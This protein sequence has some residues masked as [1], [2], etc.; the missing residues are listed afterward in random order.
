MLAL[1]QLSE[2]DER[3]IAKRLFGYVYSS[4]ISDTGFV[5]HHSDS[6]WE[7]VCR[8]LRYFDPQGEVHDGYQATKSISQILEGFDALSGKPLPS[9]EAFLD[10]ALCLNDHCNGIG[11]VAFNDRMTFDSELHSILVS[12]DLLAEDGTASEPLLLDAIGRWHFFDPTTKE[13]TE[14]ASAFMQRVAYKAWE[15]ATPSDRACL[16]ADPTKLASVENWFGTRWH[17]GAWLARD[18][19][20]RFRDLFG[21]HNSLN[22]LVPKYI[23]NGWYETK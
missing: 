16:I 22:W 5:G 19:K 8:F 20:E 9:I 18:E 7:Q 13:L 4:S 12:L 10:V 21:N 3:S 1:F 11:A 2:S 17:L 14:A 23:R 6:S 15:Q